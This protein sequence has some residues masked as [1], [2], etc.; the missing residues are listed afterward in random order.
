MS[1]VRTVTTPS[2]GKRRC[3]YDDRYER[4]ERERDRA[5]ERDDRHRYERQANG[6]HRNSEPWRNEGHRHPQRNE[7]WRNGGRSQP[8][9]D[10]KPIDA[11]ITRV[12]LGPDGHMRKQIFAALESANLGNLLSRGLLTGTGAPKAYADQVLKEAM[13]C[14]GFLSEAYSGT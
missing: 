9:R 12:S 3:F 6:G 14:F 4:D 11:S 8:P 1:T 5:S 10:K 2:Y 7:Q 13:W